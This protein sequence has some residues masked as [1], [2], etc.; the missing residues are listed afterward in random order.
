MEF[1]DGLDTRFPEIFLKT[2]QN[3]L[4]FQSSESLVTLPRMRTFWIPSWICLPWIP[5][6]N[7]SSN[8]RG[9]PSISL[10]VRSIS[11]SCPLHTP[12]LFI[13]PPTTLDTSPHQ[14]MNILHPLSGRCGIN[15]IEYCACSTLHILCFIGC[16]QR[17]ISLQWLLCF[18]HLDPCH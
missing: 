1:G 7:V 16:G 12:T 5:S 10:I 3:L 18:A 4:C 9:W 8:H 13:A 2:V 17:V 6:D 11:P 14:S 15:F